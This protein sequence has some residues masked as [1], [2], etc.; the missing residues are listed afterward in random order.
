MKILLLSLLLTLASCGG[1]GGSGGSASSFSP[2]NFVSALNSTEDE[3][4]QLVVLPGLTV[5]DRNSSD[6]WFVIYDGKNH[7]YKA[8]TL[9]YM[10][11]LYKN[12]DNDQYKT[13]QAFRAATT[14]GNG[15]GKNYE[16]VSPFYDKDGE[17]VGADWYQQR[18]DD[19][20]Y[21]GR[22]TGLTYEDSAA[23]T[24]VS[25]MAK[26]SSEA[27]LMD[28]AAKI[29]VLY[30][31]DIASS[32]T[33]MN[34]GSKIQTMISRNDNEFT[35]ADKRELSNDVQHILG[36]SLSD[37]E[38]SLQSSQSK[39]VMLDKIAEKIGTSANNLEE[40]ILPVLFGV[41]L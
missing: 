28:K 37:L 8:V 36:V 2:Q 15:D 30:N 38:N 33:L 34:L 25:L 3:K 1:S 32:M 40:K 17:S 20:Y 9:Q 13:A 21:R 24:D 6:T 12:S 29:S 31:L 16:V 11:E 14:F 18:S 41:Q 7:N 19:T 27:K 5:R 4:S 23:I 10:W 22:T 26:M 35:E 39:K